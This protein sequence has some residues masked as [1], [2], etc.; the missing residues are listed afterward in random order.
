MVTKLKYSKV[1]KKIKLR[2]NSNPQIVTKPTQ[3][4]QDKTVTKLEISNCDKT[5]T[6]K[7]KN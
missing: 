4:N 6:K 2:L 1:K 5:R 7:L 3:L